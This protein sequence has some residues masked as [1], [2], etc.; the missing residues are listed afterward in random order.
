MQFNRARFLSSASTTY[1]EASGISV[2]TNISSFAREYSTHFVREYRSVS[3][4]FHRRIGSSIRAVNRRSCSSSLTENQYLMRMMPS[5]TS[6]R[7]K[8]G[9]CCRN[10]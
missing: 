6:S 4:S 2:C 8:I 9:H 7:S 1:Q 3:E 10:R 5:S